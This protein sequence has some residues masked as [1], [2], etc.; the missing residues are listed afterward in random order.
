MIDLTAAASFM[1]TH[2]RVL[3]RRRFALLVGQEPPEG[4]LDALAGYANADGGYGWGLEPDLRD[5]ES[6]PAGAL[7]AFE[8]LVDVGAAHESR[9]D[10]ALRLARH[11]LARRRRT[12]LRPRR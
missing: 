10:P 2:A 7:H 8:A 11:R 3:D 9:G 4:V 1:A 6:Q 12:A 5:P